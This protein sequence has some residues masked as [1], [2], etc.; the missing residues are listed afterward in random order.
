M[1]IFGYHL[2]I[3]MF[4]VYSSTSNKIVLDRSW[5]EISGFSR[6]VAEVVARLGVLR[7]VGWQFATD[8]SE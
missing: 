8:I 6:A 1:V 4:F 2:I 3:L 7:C 5:C